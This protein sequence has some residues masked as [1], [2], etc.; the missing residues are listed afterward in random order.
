[1]KRRAVVEILTALREPES[2][3]RVTISRLADGNITYSVTATGRSVAKARE[4]AQEAFRELGKFAKEM[5]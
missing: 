4:N 2:R 3:P 1:M 5:K